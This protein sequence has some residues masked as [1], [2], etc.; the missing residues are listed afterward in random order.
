M[1]LE[2]IEALLHL[3]QT[4]DITSFEVTLN[5]TSLRFEFDTPAE[6]RQAPAEE[7]E[8]QS[9]ARTIT[10]PAVGIFRARHPLATA[11]RAATVEA[12]T[13]AAFIQSGPLLF[14]ARASS[15]GQ[16]GK[17]LVE[18]GEGVGFGTKLFELV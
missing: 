4:R 14:T 1:T 10:S 18:E 15:K 13:P 8:S 6:E 17:A 2:E 11:E 12:D 3:A 16:M 9:N 5:G 7:P